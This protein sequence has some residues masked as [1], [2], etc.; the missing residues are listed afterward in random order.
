MARQRKCGYYWLTKLESRIRQAIHAAKAVVCQAGVQHFGRRG[1]RV[2]KPQII[3]KCI[4]QMLGRHPVNE[5]AHFDELYGFI[6]N[7]VCK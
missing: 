1:L 6:R 2:Q 4:G 3:V 5:F 7:I